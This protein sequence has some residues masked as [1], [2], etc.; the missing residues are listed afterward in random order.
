MSLKDLLRDATGTVRIPP[1]R[2]Y[3]QLKLVGRK[4]LRIEAAGVVLDGSRAPKGQSGVR[5]Q[6]CE[7]VEVEALTVTGWNAKAGTG[8]HAYFATDCRTLKLIDGY[9]H[10]CDGSG[11]L[12]GSCSDVLIRGGNWH[13]FGSHCV[14]FSNGG[15]A[16]RVEGATCAR[17]GRCGVQA[18]GRPKR[19]EHVRVVD[20]VFIHCRNVAVQMAFVTDGLVSGCKG[21]G[22]RQEVVFWDDGAGR[23]G[24]CRECR[25]VGC[26]WT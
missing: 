7:G 1:G 13:D 10:D 18:N 9:G 20:C 26:V 3:E 11:V 4:D 2:Y 12:T 6:N 22:N 8:G 24:E 19:M 17:A 15:R 21:Q 25:Q 16:L 5:L 23:K 14:Y